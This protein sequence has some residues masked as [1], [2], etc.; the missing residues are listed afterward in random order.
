MNRA[1][2]HILTGRYAM[3][4]ASLLN[5]LHL[6]YTF[7]VF[8][9]WTADDVELLTSIFTQYYTCTRNETCFSLRFALLEF[10]AAW[11]GTTYWAHLQRW[12][13]RRKPA[14]LGPW[15]IGCPKKSVGNYHSTMRKIQKQRRS[16]LRH[17]GSLELRVLLV[18]RI[19]KYL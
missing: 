9:S 17:G 19:W 14:L 4:L 13:R 7:I 2:F 18:S 12:S 8:L 15:P 10:Y 1:T 5:L 6:L 11:N 3:Q 16:R